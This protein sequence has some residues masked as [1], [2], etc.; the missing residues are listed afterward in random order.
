MRTI[1]IGDIHGCSKALVG[2][3][4]EIAPTS[5]DQLVFL[6]DYVDR[7][8]DSKGVLRTLIELQQHCSPVFLLGNHEIMF[9]GALRGLDPQLWL[10][11]GG[12]QTLT[13]FGGRLEN[14]GAKEIAF[15]AGCKSY[16]ETENQIFV[17]A[18]FLPDLALED[19]PEFNLYW[20]HL[21]ERVPLPHVSGKHVYLG[22]TPQPFGR[23]GQFGHFTCLDTACV[24]GF[25][26]TGMDVHT[27]EV[28][29]V[30]KEGH[31]RENWKQIKRFW[32][33]LKSWT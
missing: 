7:G 14:V 10:Q 3:L 30:S 25:W 19:Q 20:E 17:H 26:L 6:G 31:P 28:W 29:Q 9:R 18:N 2:L 21:S 11:T 12:Q 23:I 33:F 22:H 4:D 16:H 8:P 1:A 32:R 24:G 13:S 15:L 5:S 27:G